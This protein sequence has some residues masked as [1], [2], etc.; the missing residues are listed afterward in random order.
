MQE[1]GKKRK[2][3]KIKNRV[4]L[5]TNFTTF[6]FKRYTRV[7]AGYLFSYLHHRLLFK[8]SR[9]GQAYERVQKAIDVAI[10]QLLL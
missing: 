8:T 7:R 4:P 5:R 9:D 2:S 3:W 10:R 1:I 6:I